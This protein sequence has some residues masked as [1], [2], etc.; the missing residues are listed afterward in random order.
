MSL[1]MKIPAKHN[2][3]IDRIIVHHKQCRH[4]SAPL[5]KFLA[6]KFRA[7]MRWDDTNLQLKRRMTCQTSEGVKNDKGYLG[8]S[9]GKSFITESIR[10]ASNKWTIS[11]GVLK[12]LT[13]WP[14]RIKR[15]LSVCNA[16]AGG[17]WEKTKELWS[18][19]TQTSKTMKI[20]F[21]SKMYI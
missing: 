14:A 10:S 11:S 2:E 16:S 3:M 13:V 1:Q 7:L 4:E 17:P 8:L 18:L 6:Q 21:R 15:S 9:E 5:Q 12:N 20:I 19:S